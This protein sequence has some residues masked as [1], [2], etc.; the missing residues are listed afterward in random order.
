M[1]SFYVARD[2]LHNCLLLLLTG[3]NEYR[4]QSQIHFVDSLLFCVCVCAVKAK[5]G[6]ANEDI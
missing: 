1:E 4:T 6:Q 2:Y 3:P 5:L